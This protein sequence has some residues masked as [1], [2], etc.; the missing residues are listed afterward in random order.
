MENY[1]S[2]PTLTNVT[3]SAN[4]ASDNGGGIFNVHDSSPYLT[5]VT[6]NSNSANTGGGMTNAANS[7]PTLINSI[8]WGNTPDQI[9]NDLDST[10]IVTYSVI[11]DTAYSDPTNVFTNPFLGPLANNGGFT[12]THALAANSPA[13]DAGDPNNCPAT[14]QRDFPRPIDGDGDGIAVCDMGAYE[15]RSA[16]FIYLPLILK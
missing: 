14:D 5:N 2:S 9:S 16:L 6:F 7:N 8:L 13:I 15:Y 12:Q 1:Q 4:I 10:A 3:F 11:D